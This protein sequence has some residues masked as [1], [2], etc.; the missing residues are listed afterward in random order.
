MR[1]AL[2]HRRALLESTALHAGLAALADPRRREWV[3]A[4]WL[5]TVSHLG[6]LENRGTLGVANTLT[7]L[8]ANLPALE[9]RLGT[10]VPVLVLRPRLRLVSCSVSV[11]SN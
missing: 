11:S 1:Q 7:L 2:H 3:V 8:G 4:S 9:N 5:L 10:A 6:M